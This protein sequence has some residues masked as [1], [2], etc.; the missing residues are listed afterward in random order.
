MSTS[1]GT[2]FVVAGE[3]LVELGDVDGFH[4]LYLLV[5]C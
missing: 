1:A 5:D 3:G 4:S 2:E